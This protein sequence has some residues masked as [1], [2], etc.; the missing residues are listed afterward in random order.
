M[1][2]AFLFVTCF[3]VSMFII[4]CSE[5]AQTERL[6]R[7]FLNK[8]VERIKPLHRQ[9]NE[10][11]WQAYTANLDFKNLQTIQN[12]TD[13]LYLSVDEAPEYYQNLLNNIHDN[14]SEYEILANIKKSGLIKDPLLKREFE[15]VFIDYLSIR[16][17]WDETEKKSVELMDK[18]YELKKKENT[19]F[20]SDNNETKEELISKWIN[21]FSSL[22]EDFKSMI[23]ALNNDV[24]GL[25]YDNYYH[26]IMANKEIDLKFIDSLTLIVDGISREDY[27]NLMSSCLNG[28]CNKKCML[29]GSMTM[30]QYRCAAARMSYPENWDSIKYSKEEFIGIAEKFFN[31]GDFDISGIYEKSNIWYEKD[32]INNSF[33]YCVDFDN[34]DLRIY[35]NINPVAYSL[36]PLIH[37]FAHAIHYQSIGK[38]VPY[39]LKDPNSIIA[40]AI[41]I[42]F[43]SKLYSSKI[44]QDELG[45]PALNDNPFFK[46]YSDPARVMFIRKMLRN[47]QFEKEIFENPDQDFNELWWNLNKE[48]LFLNPSENEKLPEWITSNHLVSN[49]GINVDYLIALVFAA[50]LEHYYPDD[51]FAELKDKIMKYGD[52]IPWY[53][54]IK[55]STGENLN[56]NYLRKSYS[57]FPE[58]KLLSLFW[59]TK[60]MNILSSRF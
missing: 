18:F 34:S 58:E 56:V 6:L 51:H 32:K 49:Q 46:N 14:A 20:S 60:R 25:G 53:E 12:Q 37:E 24:K 33:F 23:K 29:S 15:K 19:F 28:G 54:L 17:N 8:H 38:D 42:Y 52:S 5:N 1:K 50:Q 41:A 7:F 2:R 3:V 43:D 4:S 57:R 13:S 26:Y 11:A 59:D 9:L 36:N 35:S 21:E 22:T 30:S 27:R 31:S 48:Y 44:I 45:L 39:L 55:L 47:I 40:E 16:N 10:A